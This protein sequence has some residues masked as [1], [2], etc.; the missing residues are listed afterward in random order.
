MTLVAYASNERLANFA[1]P[2]THNNRRR[3][4]LLYY[5]SPPP[6]NRFFPTGLALETLSGERAKTVKGG[7]FCPL[8]CTWQRA[9][10]A[11]HPPR[12]TALRQGMKQG[13]RSFVDYLSNL[14][15]STISSYETLSYEIFCCF[16][17]FSILLSFAA[18]SWTS[19]LFLMQSRTL[20]HQ[21]SY[22]RRLEVI[23]A[24]AVLDP[25][26]VRFLPP[27]PP[28]RF[29]RTPL[30]RA[31][32]NRSRAAA[33]FA[34]PSFPLYLLPER[35][36]RRLRDGRDMARRPSL[37]HS[38]FPSVRSICVRFLNDVAIDPRRPTPPPSSLPISSRSAP[39]SLTYHKSPSFI[40]TLLFPSLCFSG[41]RKCVLHSNRTL[42]PSLPSASGGRAGRTRS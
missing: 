18:C 41:F 40:P 38:L 9:A 36:S 33:S 8:Y 7:N 17:A 11:H 24:T 27:S 37:A 29:P 28:T 13:R 35:P 21:T 39:P 4:V 15:V 19:E 34:F 2:L 30:T 6:R 1:A 20:H 3:F 22:H 32:A 31:V 23:P 25:R 26:F 10:T 42:P 5:D 12:D 14:L 16:D